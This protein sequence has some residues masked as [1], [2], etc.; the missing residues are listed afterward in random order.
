MTTTKTPPK[1]A[2]GPW[3]VLVGCNVPAGVGELRFEAGE[4]LKEFPALHL[5]KALER[6]LIEKADS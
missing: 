6:G 1:M 2:P 4:L 3:K 5:T